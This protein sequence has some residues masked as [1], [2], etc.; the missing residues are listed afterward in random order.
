MGRSDL[1]PFILAGPVIA[2]LTFV[3]DLVAKAEPL[4]LN[5]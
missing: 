3:A 4:S 1:Y 5:N 2:K